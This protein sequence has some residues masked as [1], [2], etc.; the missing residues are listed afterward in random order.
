MK[1]VALFIALSLG[2]LG[3]SE[4]EEIVLVKITKD[5]PYIYTTHKGHK[6]KIMRIQDPDHLLLD[7]Y[8]KTSRPCPPFCLHPVKVDKDIQTIQTVEMI[9]F[10]RDK[11][12]SG[13]GVVIDARLKDWYVLETIPSAINVPFTLLQKGDKEVA[14]QLFEI[15]GMKVKENGEWDFS[16]AKEL[17]VFCNGVWCDQSPRL[18]KGLIKYGYPKEKIRYY[19]GGMQEWKLLGLTTVVEK[20]K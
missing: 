16:N 4:E 13:E 6:I 18:I 17:A 1:K 11:V 19:R 15:L 5:I 12:N 7:D 2:L 10:I 20:K 9:K 8:S 3:A 14:R